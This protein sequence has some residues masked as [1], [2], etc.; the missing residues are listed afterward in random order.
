MKKSLLFLII[1]SILIILFSYFQIKEKI[2]GPFR[3]SQPKTELTNEEIERILAEK[4]TDNDGLSDA[5]EIFKYKTSIYLTDSDSDG[6]NDKEEIEAGS[7]P[8]N[9]ESTPLHKVVERKEIEIKIPE[10]EP[11]PDEIREFLIK[12]GLDKEIVDKIDDE[13][14]KKLYNET[15]KETG[16]KPEELVAGGLKGI[17]FSKILKEKASSENINELENLTPEQ[18][19]Q[20]LIAS[21]ADPNLLNQIDDQ[22]LKTLFLQAIKQSFSP[23]LLP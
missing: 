10:K 22:T 20:L 6:Y 5:E 2:Q 15:V 21:G 8:I 16:V 17:D 18:I 11:T 19:R 1:F 9:P 3:L 4:D 23:Q 7:D 13:T 14:L 12:A